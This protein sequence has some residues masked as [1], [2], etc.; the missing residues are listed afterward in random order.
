MRFRILTAGSG[1]R[2]QAETRTKNAGRFLLRPSS[3][4]FT[5]SA[6]MTAL[7]DVDRPAPESTPRR[8]RRDRRKQTK[9]PP[10]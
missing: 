1:A 7:Q 10:H 3:R 2:P 4:D 6:N 8:R 5:L 9:I